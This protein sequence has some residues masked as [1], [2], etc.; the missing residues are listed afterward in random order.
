MFYLYGEHNRDSVKLGERVELFIILKHDNVTENLVFLIPEKLS[1]VKLEVWVDGFCP[2]KKLKELIQTDAS[3]H[4][5]QHMQSV[6]FFR[7]SIHYLLLFNT[8]KGFHQPYNRNAKLMDT[9]E[10][11]AKICFRY[12]Y[13]LSKLSHGFRKLNVF[14]LN[15]HDRGYFYFQEAYA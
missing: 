5:Y 9:C 4:Q 13:T 7:Q 12:V 11:L 14:L 10:S 6:L 8:V 3:D 1:G 15:D 2:T